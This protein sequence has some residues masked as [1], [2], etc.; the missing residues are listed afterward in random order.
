MLVTVCFK[1]L[2]C[3]FIYHYILYETLGAAACPYVS[4]E[5]HQ[6]AR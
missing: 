3:L 5:S 4:E 2:H 6:N 1:Y